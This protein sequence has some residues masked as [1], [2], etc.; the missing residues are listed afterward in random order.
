MRESFVA[1]TYPR[2]GRFFGWI[3]DGCIAAILFLVPL[4]VSSWSIDPIDGPKQTILVSFTVIALIAW[5]GQALCN[6]RLAINRSW[7]HMVVAIALVGYGVASALSMDRFVSFVGRA[8]Q[9]HWAFAS[10]CAMAV[11]YLLVS[12]SIRSVERMYRFLL[13]VLASS[14]LVG[15]AALLQ[16][17]GIH[18]FAF[19]GTFTSNPSFTFVG[20]L[21]ALATHQAVAL[22]ISV[23]MLLYACRSGVCSMWGKSRVGCYVSSVVVWIALAVAIACEVV[24]DYSPAWIALIVGMIAVASVPL[25]RREPM[26]S[27]LQLVIPGIVLLVSIGLLIFPTSIRI[28]LP[29]EVSPSFQ[30]SLD[31]ARQE[32]TEHPL[33]GSGPGTWVFD[34]SKYRSLAV[35]VSPYWTIRFEQGFSAVFTAI[36]TMGL[37]GFLLWAICALSLLVQVGWRT[38]TNDMNDEWRAAMVVVSALLTLSVLFCLTN[39]AMSLFV[40]AA[41]LF[42][43]CAA[44]M[45]KREVAWETRKSVGRAAALSFLFIVTLVGAFSLLWIVVQRAIA[46]K[47]TAQAVSAYTMSRPLSEIIGPLE[48]SMK[49]NPWS[50]VAPRNL[51]QAY[52]MQASQLL[53]QPASADRNTRVNDAIASALNASKRSIQLSP[54]NVENWASSAFILQSLSSASQGADDQ[55]INMFTEALVREPNNPIFYTELGKIHLMRADTKQQLVQSKDEQVKKDAQTQMNAELDQAAQALNQAIQ[56]KPD[57][58][59]AHYAMALVYE[60]QGRGKDAIQKLEQVL[61]LDPKNIGVGFELAI[62]YYRDGQKDRSLNLFEQIVAFEPG[63]SNA[64]WY[65]ASI[66]EERGRYDDAIAQLKAIKT[67]NDQDAAAVSDRTKQLIQERDRATAPKVQAL[68]EPIGEAKK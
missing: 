40:L 62:L 52:M 33:F 27:Q 17:F 20:T 59:A 18:P 64:R 9:I 43:C 23:G 41:T 34:Y 53:N 4:V 7:T 67:V 31:I 66:Y 55:A 57:Y 14:S 6:Q 10:V 19:L 22:V 58:A 39:A 56:A 61:K 24:I 15:I 50:D 60:R 8:G 29:S 32:L 49:L 25:F 37:V 30:A 54:S 3:V 68:P 48:T 5:I 16:F 65:L 1:D 21:N 36:A 42:A 47:D 11:L 2:L 63:Y 35:N 12:T 13:V 51:A 38:F 46:D 26:K 44:M 28:S 45:E